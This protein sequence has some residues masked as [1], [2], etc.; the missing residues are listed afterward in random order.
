MGNRTPNSLA[1]ILLTNRLIESEV[2]PFDPSDF[3]EVVRNIHDP[4]LLIGL[5][6]SE[7]AEKLVGDGK[8][9][10]R[11]ARRLDTATLLAFEL[12]NLEQSGLRVITAFDDE[13]PIA[14]KG[15][16]HKSAPPLV[17]VAGPTDVL[18]SNGLGIVGSRNVSAEAASSAKHAA[19][20]A[21][22][23]GMTIISGGARGSDQVAMNGAH[24]RGGKVVGILADSLAKVLKDSSVRHAISDG[25]LTLLTP[26]S[27][28]TGFNVG[29][30]MGR[31]KLIYA[32]SQ[33]TF[34]VSA[35]LEKG[36]SWS[37]AVEA[38]RKDYSPVAVWM[39]E[40]AGTGN[41][42]L[43]K[44]GALPITDIKELFEEVPPRSAEE[45]QMSLGL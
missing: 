31:N 3:W 19:T 38:L 29:N 45:R 32:L 34:V 27:P 28:S 6:A 9:A 14:W 35:D 7:I 41:A 12:E 37:G 43:V 18:N 17:Y 33:I 42:A 4:G 15:R 16:L 39:G 30:A 40:G 36:G 26:F 13:Y 1:T 21:A 44:K 8:S 2:A 20:L 23:K 25:L 11:I 22:E 24:E 5:S 10:E